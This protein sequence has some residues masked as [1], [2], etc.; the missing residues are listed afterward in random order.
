MESHGKHGEEERGLN[1]PV[2]RVEVTGVRVDSRVTLL[3]ETN[4]DKHAFRPDQ[5]AFYF[6]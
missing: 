1:P 4:D 2:C 6:A 3:G 5:D